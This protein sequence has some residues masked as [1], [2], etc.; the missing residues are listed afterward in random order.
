MYATRSYRAFTV[1]AIPTL[2]QVYKPG[3][4]E[5]GMLQGRNVIA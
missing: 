3:Q 5:D 4:V 2:V 1:G